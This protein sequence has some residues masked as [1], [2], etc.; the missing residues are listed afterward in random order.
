MSCGIRWPTYKRKKDGLI[1]YCFFFMSRKGHHLLNDLW[2]SGHLH[3]CLLCIVSIGS[4]WINSA[5]SICVEEKEK[6]GK[7]EKKEKV[8]VYGA[9]NNNKKKGRLDLFT[10]QSLYPKH[11]NYFNMFCPST[12]LFFICAATW[13]VFYFFLGLCH[14]SHLLSLFC[15]ICLLTLFNY[16][17]I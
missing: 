13:H 11:F 6:K 4:I 14:L 5:I 3:E 17:L 15:S 16:F 12:P 1:L 10:K 2:H 7:R 8:Y 9:N